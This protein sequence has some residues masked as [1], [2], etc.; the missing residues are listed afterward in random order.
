MDKM[1]AKLS[2]KL[3]KLR[4]KL[5]T[6]EWESRI[7]HHPV[8]QWFYGKIQRSI[9]RIMNHIYAHTSSHYQAV[10][11]RVSDEENPFLPST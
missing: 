9:K 2:R 3:F 5:K 11:S 7:S 4:K 8:R 6:R 1:L 10:M